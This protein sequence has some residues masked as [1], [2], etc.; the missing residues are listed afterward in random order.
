MEGAAKALESSNTYKL[1]H[2]KDFFTILLIVLA[3]VF[4]PLHVFV[5]A[6]ITLLIY[7]LIND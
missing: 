4:I 6:F 2:M 5:I 1:N 3:V 7:K